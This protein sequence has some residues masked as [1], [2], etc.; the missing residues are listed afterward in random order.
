MFYIFLPLKYN[1]IF[2][3]RIMGRYVRSV[4]AEVRGTDKWWND[5]YN[6]N[7]DRIDSLA[8]EYAL[9]D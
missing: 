8:E 5:D 9:G 2:F 6:E 7:D 4:T 1:K 3:Q